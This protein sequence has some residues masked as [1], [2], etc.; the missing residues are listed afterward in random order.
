MRIAT[1]LDQASRRFDR[2]AETDI[3]AGNAQ[4]LAA[5]LVV[6]DN[7]K[8]QAH[9]IESTRENRFVAKRI[10]IWNLCPRHK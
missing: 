3:A 10:E 7:L 4:K 9:R 2:L 8:P 6:F 1:A 5:R